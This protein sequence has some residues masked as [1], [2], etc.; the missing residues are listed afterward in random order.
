VSTVIV[1]VLLSQRLLVLV[2]EVLEDI[3]DSLHQGN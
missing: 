3:L 2:V 1:L